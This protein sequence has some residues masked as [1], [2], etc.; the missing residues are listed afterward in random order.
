M[1]DLP[2]NGAASSALQ[3]ATE[4]RHFPRFP[5]EI[6]HRIFT[7]AIRKPNAHFVMARRVNGRGVRPN[8]WR[9]AVYP[10]PKQQDKSGYRLLETLASVNG[11][12]ST[13]VRL[14]TSNHQARLPF[15]ALTNRID[16]AEDVV[17]IGF[18]TAY[19]GHHW[20]E[21]F[22]YFHP[23]N[24][25][26]SALRFDQDYS[27]VQFYYIQKVAFTYN[28]S[29]WHMG[30]EIFRCSQP[31]MNHESWKICPEELFGFL[32]LFRNLKEVYIIL[33]PGRDS[34]NKELA[35]TYTKNFFT[36][37]CLPNCLVQVLL[38]YSPSRTP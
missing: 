28:N 4:F 12:A 36:C 22:C 6:Q 30:A 25:I 34:Y 2:A 15:A 38:V 19:H 26:I 17:V 31:H 13:A 24:Q 9:L 20:R 8:E 33:P 29:L 5:P 23:V 27:Y 32:N 14:A 35:R 18:A 21:P 37:K 1:A 7:E 3:A 16:G 11:E 10:I